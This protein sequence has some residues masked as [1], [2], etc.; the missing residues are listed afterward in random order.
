MDV[1]ARELQRSRVG[2]TGG[3]VHEDPERHRPP[4]R[5]LQKQDLHGLLAGL[6]QPTVRS[7]VS[8][9]ISQSVSSLGLRCW[10]QLTLKWS[11]VAM[12]EKKSPENG[13][14]VVQHHVLGET[15]A[16]ALR[17]RHTGAGAVNSAVQ[18]AYYRLWHAEL[19]HLQRRK[20]PSVQRCVLEMVNCSSTVALAE[21]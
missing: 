4:P 21:T 7:C 13:F 10:M 12:F 3:A 1:R 16:N 6:S 14:S 15:Q 11:N 18:A 8:P 9:F 19:S 17:V 20:Q 5:G 2:G